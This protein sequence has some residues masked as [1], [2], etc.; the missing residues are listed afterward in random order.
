MQAGWIR[1]DDDDDDPEID[2]LFPS[3]L[4]FLDFSTLGFK[5]KAPTRFPL[6]LLI[7]QEI[8]DIT[9]LIKKKAQNNGGSVIVSG[10]TWNR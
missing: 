10:Q 3:L 4:S 8:K 9:D 6:P 7:R 1:V 5:E 2:S